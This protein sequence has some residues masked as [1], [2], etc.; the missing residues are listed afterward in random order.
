MITNLKMN[1][2]LWDRLARG[3]E[4]SEERLMDCFRRICNEGR[5]AKYTGT[6]KYKRLILLKK[7]DKSVLYPE[8]CLEEQIPELP[9]LA[10]P[11]KD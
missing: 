11:G 3:E 10:K 6:E 1:K 7:P 2:N 4:I 5:N 9:G 8:V